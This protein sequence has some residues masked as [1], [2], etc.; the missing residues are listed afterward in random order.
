MNEAIDY[1]KHYTYQE[2]LDLERE[3]DTRFEFFEGE[4]FA[5]AGATLNHNEIA[6]N[7]NDSIK[8]VFRP[9]GCRSFQENAKVEVAK[10]SYYVYPD[11]VLTCDK[12]DVKADY[13]IKNPV[14]IAEV[15]S[16]STE[17]YNRGFKWKRYKRI[18]SLK[19]YLLI[20]Q[21]SVFVELFTRLGNSDMF[22]YQAFENMED[23]IPFGDIEFTLAVKSIYAGIVLKEER[24]GE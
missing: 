9:K 21:E 14:L 19:Y 18:P 15:L 1:K 12:E 20:D 17:Q 11:V 10:N 3:T 22:S 7:I 5:M 4:V 13:L 6:S 23:T 24:T 8:S 16:K 2:Y